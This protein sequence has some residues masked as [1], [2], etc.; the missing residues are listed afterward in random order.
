MCVPALSHFF[1]GLPAP[2]VCLDRRSRIIHSNDAASVLFGYSSKEF[3]DRKFSDLLAP[4]SVGAQ[5]L[6]T[7]SSSD[8]NL[9]ELGWRHQSGAIFH[10]K[11]RH[12]TIPAAQN[13]QV[14]MWVE[15]CREDSEM[16]E[17]VRLLT[18][19]REAERLRFARDLH[20]GAIQELLGMGFGLTELRR[21]VQSQG[22]ELVGQPIVALQADVVRIARILRSLVS[23]LRPAGLEE[24]GL[25][26]TLE[27]HVAKV[28]RDISGHHPEVRLEIQN[29]PEL[30]SP[31]ELCL[32]RTAQEALRNSIK[33]GKASQILISLKRLGSE[34]LLLVKDD[35]CGFEV[36]AHLVDL[37]RSQ[38][39]GLAGM[40]ERV[41]LVNGH[42]SVHSI[43]GK[44]TEVRVT[45]SLEDK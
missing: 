23:E 2:V 24:F 41:Q 13:G 7:E 1:D 27:G 36:A 3:L 5:I 30:T 9:D 20:D 22:V 16:I 6:T 8:R 45:V 31:Q 26:D 32:F 38:N 42:L 33:H 39:F 44:G 4:T 18:E 11:S 40:L 12:H 35:G 28:L 19:Q 14:W 15:C 10:A 43:I 34:A 17:A 29:L 25:R 21:Q 37:T